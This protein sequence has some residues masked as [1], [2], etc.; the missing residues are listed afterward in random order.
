MRK[1]NF[2]SCGLDYGVYEG[3]TQEQAQDAYARN[4]NYHSWA[5]MVERAEEF[6]GNNV[7]VKEVFTDN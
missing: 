1:F 7:E 3:E 6:G 4:S 5:D 2:S